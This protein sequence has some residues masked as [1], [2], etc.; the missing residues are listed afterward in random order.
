MELV[1]ILVNI[2]Q[3]YD[4]ADAFVWWRDAHGLFVKSSYATLVNIYVDG[5]PLEENK[6]KAFKL[7]WSSN[8]PSNIQAFVWRLIL[9]WMQTRDELSKR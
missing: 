7:L 6:D 5:L 1:D 8:I 9:N 3:I 4:S 2:T